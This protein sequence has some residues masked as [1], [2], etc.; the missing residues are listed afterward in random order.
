MLQINFIYEKSSIIGKVLWEYLGGKEV[1]MTEGFLI[2]SCFVIGTF[3]IDVTSDS[4]NDPQGWNEK[5]G[6][7]LPK[8]CKQ[9]RAKLEFKFRLV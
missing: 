7:R 6:A 1:G 9:Q 5:T 2:S 8:L 3:I 4:N